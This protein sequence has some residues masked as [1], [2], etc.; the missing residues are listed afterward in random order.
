[1]EK[2]VYGCANTLGSPVKV[3]NFL[4][5]QLGWFEDLLVDNQ[6]RLHTEA[7][8]AAAKKLV[9]HKEVSVIE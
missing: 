8:K 9:E 4:S 5:F 2:N 3:S 1:M 6:R 7:T